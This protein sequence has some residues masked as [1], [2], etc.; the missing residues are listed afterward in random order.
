M[1]E[2]FDPNEQQPTGP[3]ISESGI[4]YYNSLLNDAKWCEEHPQQASFLRTSVDTALAATGQN[5]EPP[6]DNRTPAQ[7]LHDHM[8]AI[9]PHR[10]E[11]YTALPATHREFASALSL[12]QNLA[13]L[14]V[15]DALS[16]VQKTDASKVL[17]DRYELTLKDAKAVLQRA[18]HL[19]EG[20]R[21]EASQLSPHAL[22]QLA[23]WGRHLAKAQ[24]S[25][26]KS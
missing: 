10:P 5:L 2:F 6:A 19:P 23:V 25:R 3:R 1:P 21:I 15:K 26:P 7:K 24:A 20:G 13:T 18:G 14:V 17:G 22:A 4:T 12:P 8:H 16:G 9:E 11:E